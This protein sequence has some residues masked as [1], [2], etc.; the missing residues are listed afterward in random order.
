M[1]SEC[2][3]QLLHHCGYRDRIEISVGWKKSNSVRSK[4]CHAAWIFINKFW[5]FLTFIMFSLGRGVYEICVNTFFLRCWDLISS[6]SCLFLFFHYLG[7]IVWPFG[8]PWWTSDQRQ[9]WSR[10]IKFAEFP[11][12]LIISYCSCICSSF[13]EMFQICRSGTGAESFHRK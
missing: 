12:I 8:L 6:L 9:G 10:W 4:T 5:L 3:N 7:P 1:L 2:S 13:V 11:R